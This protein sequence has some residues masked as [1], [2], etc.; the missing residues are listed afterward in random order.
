MSPPTVANPHPSP[1]PSPQPRPSRLLRRAVTM[2]ASL[3]VLL[4]AVLVVVVTTGLYRPFGSSAR[5]DLI[6]HQVKHE[7]LQLTI[8]ERGTLEAAENSDIVCRVK[9]RSPNST[10]ATTI[11]W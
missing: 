1:H 8:T 10:I 3:P 11:R 9:A 6:L 7:R 5:P 4:L 2:I